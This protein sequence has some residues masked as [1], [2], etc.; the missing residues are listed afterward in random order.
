M[1]PLHVPPLSPKWAALAP[2]QAVAP[3]ELPE[4]LQ[5][6]LTGFILVL[7]DIEGIQLSKPKL[8]RA[9][10]QALYEFGLAILSSIFKLVES[11]ISWAW[12][13][14]NEFT[15]CVILLKAVS[16]AF[17]TEVESKTLI[18]VKLLVIELKAS[19]MPGLTTL[20]IFPL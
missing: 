12:A 2:K 14:L 9:V 1:Q 18:F 15:T 5:D 16:I 20:T 19:D 13:V 11:V 3:A 17:W 10:T 8:G 6:I 4:T 7:G